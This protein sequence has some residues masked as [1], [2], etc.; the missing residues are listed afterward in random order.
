MIHLSMS[1]RICFVYH[2]VQI[3]IECI[4]HNELEEMCE[5]IGLTQNSSP[6]ILTTFEET[7]RN[8]RRKLRT[9]T[10]KQ[11]DTIRLDILSRRTVQ[12][13]KDILLQII[14]IVFYWLGRNI[15][16]KIRDPD[17]SKI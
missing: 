14:E 17:I 13:P 10:I 12:W 1:L 15:K 3:A 2:D 16:I 9:N 8:E 4:R 5:I 6:I 7:R 11:S